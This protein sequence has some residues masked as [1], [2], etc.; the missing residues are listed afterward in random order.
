M[1]PQLP[2]STAGAAALVELAAEYAV[3]AERLLAGSGITEAAIADPAAE[4]TAA[5]E[6]AVVRNLLRELGHV[7]GLGL[8]AGHRYHVGLFGIWGFALL[9]SPTIRDALGLA[10]RFVDLTNSF[11]RLAYTESATE[12]LLEFDDSGVP[13]DVRTFLLER[14]VASALRLQ[15]DILRAPL[16]GLRLELTLPEPPDAGVFAEVTGVHPVFGAPRNVLVVPHEALDRPLPQ[17]HPLV[18]ATAQDQC[19]ALLRARH[20][21]VGV[22]G[23]VRQVLLAGRPGRIRQEEVAA[24]L[25]LSPRTL[26]RRLAAEETTFRD[27][28]TE[29]TVLLAQE[30]LAAHLTVED[31]AAR[32]GYAGAPAFT[33]AFKKATGTTPGSW[34]RARRTP[35]RP[36]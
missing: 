15:Q 9:T 26:H 13:A 10:V 18:A 7:P 1:L 14:D 12:A 8:I 3:P 19:A 23:R 21:R 6:L 5:A 4:V 17:A 27:L 2:R 31:V 33:V 36:S 35:T 11:S 30:M 25:A 28:A 34:A 16:P 22:A 29:T 20:E 32:L 24:A